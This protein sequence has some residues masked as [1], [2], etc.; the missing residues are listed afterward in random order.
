MNLT[1]AMSVLRKAEA[2]RFARPIWFGCCRFGFSLVELL[3]VI[4]ILALLMSL[5]LP[6]I[7]SAREAA[8][9][10]ECAN[11]VKNLSLGMHGFLA[12]R[13]QF[14][15]AGYW[16]GGPNPDKNSPGPHHNW[17]VD[18]IPYLDRQDL[19]DRWN[20]DQ[21]ATFPANQAIASI[22][23]K[24]LTCPSDWTT[25]GHGDLSYALNGGIG[26]SFFY[27]GV[28]D[29]VADPFYVPLDL[30][31]NGV[32]CANPD[33]ADGSPSDRDLFFRLGMFFSENWQ[34][35]G[36]PGYHGTTRHHTAVSV[37]DGLSNTLMLGENCRTG[38][39]AARPAINWATGDGR[40]SR[41]FFSHTI[42]R[43]NSCTAAAVDFTRANQGDHAIN[44]GRNMAEGESPFLNSFHPGGVN[45]ALGDGSVRF[46]SDQIDGR[47]LYHLF[48]PDGNGLRNT[49]LD[50]GVA[51]GNF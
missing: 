4:S 19:A 33:S 46:L 25:T 7:Q 11:H 42:C 2:K 50:A 49:P 31:G 17:V 13:R 29:C 38:V 36:T 40:Q 34:F 10:V 47:V 23:L 21:L 26:D 39:D 51:D 32:V 27:N 6:A 16:G 22:H 45:I 8:R 14:P 43:D 30:N 48:T 24:V 9:R 15:A 44:A 5:I 3:V 20:W 35:E 18:L 37:R 28:Q 12:A 41:L 1:R